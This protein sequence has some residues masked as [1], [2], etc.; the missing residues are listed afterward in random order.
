M[1]AAIIVVTLFG[2]YLAMTFHL[3]QRLRKAESGKMFLTFCFSVSLYFSHAFLY[4]W[5]LYH[6]NDGDH[7]V[8]FIG[9]IALGI[10]MYVRWLS[11]W[12][13]YLIVMVVG[14][15]RSLFFLCHLPYAII[16]SIV[17]IIGACLAFPGIRLSRYVVNKF[18]QS[19]EK[20]EEL[21]K[22]ATNGG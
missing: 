5:L 1:M 17:S 8:Y 11:T 9:F 16:K 21:T 19:K 2:C 14:G 3:D 13:H 4:M 12:G 22:D 7:H 15:I 18:R 6:V 20:R 10:M